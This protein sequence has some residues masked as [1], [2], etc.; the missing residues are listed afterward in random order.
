MGFQPLTFIDLLKSNS[1][2]ATVTMC[3]VI[4]LKLGF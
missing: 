3:Q 2:F 1:P 4:G